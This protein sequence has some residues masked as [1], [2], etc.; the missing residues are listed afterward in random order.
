MKLFKGILA[1]SLLM[2]FTLVSCNKDDDDDSSSANM[3]ATIDSDSWSS[4][5][6]LSTMSDNLISVS[7]TSST[8][9]V[10]SVLIYGVE[11]GTY[12]FSLNAT[13]SSIKCWCTYNDVSLTGT[14]AYVSTSG[15]VNLTEVDTV[16]KTVSGTFNFTVISTSLKI[17]N[18]KGGVFN[19][20]SYKVVSTEN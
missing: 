15:T 7:G 16:N 5:S 13:G 9:D 11:E 18:I 17:I 14:T 19:K 12:D 3:S 8:L 2:M 6:R 20:L 1:L 10:V 4:A